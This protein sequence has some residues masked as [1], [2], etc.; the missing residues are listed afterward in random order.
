MEDAPDTQRLAEVLRV[1]ANPNRLELLHQLRSPRSVS[2]IE[3]HPEKVHE[4]EDPGRPISHQAVRD[5]LAKLKRIGVLTIERHEV[6]GNIVDEFALN[7]QRLFA[8]IEEF[9]KLAELRSLAPAGVERTIG[10][11]REEVTETPRGPRFILVR[12]QGEGRVFR[13]RREN[14]AAGRGW[15]IGRKRGLAVSLDY[16]PFVSTENAE[17]LMNGSGFTLLDIRSSRNG[18]FLNFEM[19]GR[20]ESRALSDGDIVSVGRTNLVFREA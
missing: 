12:G 13:L 3:L 7:H 8:I 20:G 14:L 18:T 10:T 6:N 9:R 1:L 5:H 17:V 2:Q 4:G 15:I 16:D 19:L 11:E